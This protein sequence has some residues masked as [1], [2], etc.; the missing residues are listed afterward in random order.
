MDIKKLLF[1]T[2]FNDLCFDALQSILT[3]R[4][5]SLNHVVFVNVIQREKVA[6]HRGLGYQKIEEIRLRETANIRFIDWAENLFEQGLEV[7]VY[8]V[9]GNLVTQVFEATRKEGADLIVIGRSQKHFLDQLYS[10]SNIIEL[11][12][13]TA[14]PVFVYKPMPDK[15]DFLDKPFQRPLLAIDWSA[16]SLRAEEYLRPLTGVVQQV[17]VIHVVQEKDLK[18]DSAMSIQKFRK[19][20]RKK[21]ERICDQMAGVGIDARAH[22]YI[23]ETVKEIERAARECQATMIVMGSSSKANWVQRWLGSVPQAIAEKSDFPA[24]IVPPVMAPETK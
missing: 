8:I 14:V 18:S 11:I 19:D 1:V 6:M 20:T 22:V 3:L 15:I 24:L 10:G 4:K 7:G 9:V 12:R 5:A 17:H 2:K 23:G 13:R 21:L 16:A